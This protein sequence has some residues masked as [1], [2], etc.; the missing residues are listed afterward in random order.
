MDIEFRTPLYVLLLWWWLVACPVFCHLEI[1]TL[2]AAL[3]LTLPTC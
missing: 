1:A 2:T 3:S